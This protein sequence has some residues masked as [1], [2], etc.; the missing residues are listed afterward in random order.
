MK[1]FVR[2]VS[3]V[4]LLSVFACGKQGGVSRQEAMQQAQASYQSG[5][6][7]LQS[8]SLLQA[9]P[10]FFQVSEALERLPA[11]MTAEELLLTSRAYYQMA[12][13]FRQKM[14]NN[15][16]IEVLRR[17][18]AYQK[19]IDDTTW[20]TRT[21]LQLANSFMRKKNSPTAR[22]CSTVLVPHT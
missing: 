3:F 2:I 16:E 6:E 14:E 12:Y 21:S 7:C 22:R 1:P 8:D 13:V 18:L 20:T 11:D 15:A 5:F 19:R 10:Y 17:A 4:V 9:L